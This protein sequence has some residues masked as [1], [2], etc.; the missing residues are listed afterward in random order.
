[1][2]SW[3]PLGFDNFSDFLQNPNSFEEYWLARYFV[4]WSS[5]GICLVI[6]LGLYWE[7]HRCQVSFS[8]VRYYGYILSN[9]RLFRLTPWICSMCHPNHLYWIPCMKEKFFAGRMGKERCWVTKQHKFTTDYLFLDSVGS[10]IKQ[11]S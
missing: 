3:A 6:F 9:K 8:L 7:N 4:E 2:S 5:L 11:F 10:V 1:M